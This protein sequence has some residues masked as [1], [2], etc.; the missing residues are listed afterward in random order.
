MSPCVSTGECTD[1]GG[2]GLLCSACTTEYRRELCTGENEPY[3]AWMR[4]LDRRCVC[5]GAQTRTAR[6]TYMFP[7]DIVVCY[8]HSNKYLKYFVQQNIHRML[9]RAGTEALIRTW[10]ATSKRKR[11]E[12]LVRKGKRQMVA[13]KRRDRSRKA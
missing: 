7:F 11:H 3:T 10:H 12:R 6:H 9:D 1:W 4:A 5:C 8:L 2:K 13:S